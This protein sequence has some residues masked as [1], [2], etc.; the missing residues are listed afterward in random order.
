MTPD[1]RSPS[2]L[3]RIRRVWHL[4]NLSHSSWA[5]AVGATALAAATE[6]LMP[7]LLQPLLD[8]GF[9]AGKL[10]LWQVPVVLMLLFVARGAASFLMQ[11]A[12]TRIT[13]LGVEHLR[14]RMF[15]KL[16]RVELSLFGEQTAS[17]LANTLVY[18]VQT[19]S[20]MLVN[21]V[22][23]LARDVLT[24]LALLGYLIYLNWKLTL[25]VALVFPAIAWVVHTLTTRLYRLTRESQ[26]AT[27][28]LAYVVEENVLA[29]RDIRLHQAQAQQAERFAVLSR[30]LR[31]L[32]LKSTVANAGMGALTQLL[33][34]VALSAVV[35]LALILSASDGT[36][37]GGFVAFIT[38]MLLLIAPLKGLSDASTPITRG[39]A[40][41]ERGLGLIE[42]HA[43]EPEGQRVPERCLGR[44]ELRGV[45]VHYGRES[46]A[47]LQ[48]IDL[49]IEP[50]ETVA[51]VGSSGSGKSTL[52]NLLPRF[53]HPSA[54]QVLIDGLDIAQWRLQ[55]LRA[56]FALVSQH[57]VM[58]NASIAENVA[59]GATVDRDRVLA[60]L[61]AAHLGELVDQQARGIDAPLGHNAM[62]LSGG[63]RQRLAIA[64][65][66][67]KDAPIVLLD[68]ATSALDTVS[69]RLVQDALRRLMGGRTTLVI[70]HRLSTIEHADRVLVIERGR[71][72][73]AG[74]P[75]ELATQGGAYA[76]LR[77]LQD[78]PLH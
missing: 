8:R 78:G 43:D 10:P 73:E 9:Q 13:N 31:Q 22:L 34:A 67:Y 17:S 38:A 6:P 18:E 58:L 40:A 28:R 33:A 46:Q 62:Q 42:S 66:L 2:I 50:G 14:E 26:D 39:L 77:Q 4:F 69:E 32:S 48:G 1:T 21:S 16:L 65:A 24:V 68:E 51:L 54:G 56:Q 63:Q 27:D 15:A 60:C 59:L 61:Q 23:K 53:V 76:R 44:I 49:C 74:R 29:H 7:A 19:G 30:A 52:V 55:A 36:T 12:L 11:F 5:L 57:V 3:H 25:V 20:V 41:L 75:A 71:I 47:A 70:A 72:V 64:R 37:V 45:S 35:T